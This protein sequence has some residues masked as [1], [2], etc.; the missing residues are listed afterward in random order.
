[1]LKYYTC[2]LCIS[3][4]IIGAELTAQ[5]ILCDG[6]KDEVFT[7]TIEKYQEENDWQNGEANEQFLF[8]GCRTVIVNIIPRRDIGQIQIL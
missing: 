5:L 3:Y 7:E 8:R 6:S 1:M 4:L 2:Y